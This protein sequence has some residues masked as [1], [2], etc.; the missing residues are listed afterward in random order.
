MLWKGRE[1]CDKDER[2]MIVYSRRCKLLV[3]EGVNRSRD[4]SGLGSRLKVG[5]TRKKQ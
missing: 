5:M 3:A 1:R 4:D 2:E